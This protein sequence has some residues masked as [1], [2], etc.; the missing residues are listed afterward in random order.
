MTI[1]TAQVRTDVL[2]GG[3]EG[4]ERK[5]IMLLRGCE[6]TTGTCAL[7]THTQQNSKKEIHIQKL[8]QISTLVIQI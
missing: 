3:W 6:C 8:T 5:A 4:D 2:A 7:D 1:I